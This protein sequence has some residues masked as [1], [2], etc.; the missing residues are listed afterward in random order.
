MEDI[1]VRVADEPDGKYA[2]EIAAEMKASAAARGTGIAHRSPEDIA[3]KIKAG[4]AVIALTTSGQWVGFSY[5][6]LWSNGEFVSNSGLVVNPRFRARGVATRIKNGD[7]C[8]GAKEI[9]GG[10]PVQHY[11][12]AGHHETEY[13][14][15]FPAGHLCRDYA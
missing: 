1:I 10:Q 6:E 15:G 9:P 8:P 14:D 3:G 11:H 7:H 2:A 12:R 4:R 5:I 13:V